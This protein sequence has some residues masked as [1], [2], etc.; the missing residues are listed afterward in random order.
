MTATDKVRRQVTALLFYFVNYVSKHLPSKRDLGISA[1]GQW[2]GSLGPHRRSQ[3][4][5]PHDTQAL[6]LNED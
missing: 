5:L 6:I 4:L 2:Y 1:G 3:K